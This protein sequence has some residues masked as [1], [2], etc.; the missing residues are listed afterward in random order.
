MATVER[1]EDLRVWQVGRNIV[2]VIYQ[3]SGVRPS[4]FGF[5]PLVN[6]SG[7]HADRGVA[8]P[9]KCSK[10]LGSDLRKRRQSWGCVVGGSPIQGRVSDPP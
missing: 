2:N 4:F 5:L 3:K 6:A 9:D 10:S 7:D 1:F 8:Q